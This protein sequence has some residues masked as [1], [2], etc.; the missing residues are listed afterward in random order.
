MSPEIQAGDVVI[1]DDTAADSIGVGD[2]I[3]YDSPESDQRITHRVVEVSESGGER[4][5]RTKGDA[6]EEAD[7]QPVPASAVVGVVQF[8][9][10][11]IGH[12]ISFASSDAGML[13]FVVVPAVALA[14]SETV[15][16]YRD[17]TGGGAGTEP[18]NANSGDGADRSGENP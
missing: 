5:F 8:H 11:L 13:L 4:A 17:A 3:T 6:N 14:V 7:A 1:V 12:V 10:P 15:S 2:V 9:V 18:S 16:L